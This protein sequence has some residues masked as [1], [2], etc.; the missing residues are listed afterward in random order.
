MNVE[1]VLSVKGSNVAT[2]HPNTT[3]RDAVQALRLHGIGALVVSP[4]GRRIEGILS[5][6]DVVR[7]LASHGPSSL[8]YPVS[9]VMTGSVMTC[10]PGDDLKHLMR[11][12]TEHRIRHVPVVANDEMVGIVSIGDVLKFRLGELDGSAVAS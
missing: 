10:A 6:R 12:M 3:V 1:H 8:D 11:L 7:K 4:D 5:E 9:G 2:I